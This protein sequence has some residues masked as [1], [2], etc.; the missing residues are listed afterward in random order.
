MRL[1]LEVEE[2]EARTDDALKAAGLFPGLEPTAVDVEALLEVHL[3]AAVDYAA[4]LPDTI[5]GYT[6]FDTPPRVAV[7]R[8]L[9]ELA[10]APG[11]SHGLLGRWRATLAHEAAHIILHTALAAEGAMTPE[12][13]VESLSGSNQEKSADW[14]EVQANMGM[15][16]LLMPRGPF[17]VAA[18]RALE[19]QPVLLPLAHDSLQAERLVSILGHEFT[20]SRE[21]TRWRLRNLGWTFERTQEKS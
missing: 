17:L 12:L 21:A 18:R 19:T 4:D 7:S 15:A 8:R 6:F 1:W 16:A 5:L 14:L 3:G 13:T 9:T 2:L 11:A 20:T 10:V